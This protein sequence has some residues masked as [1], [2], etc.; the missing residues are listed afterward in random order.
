MRDDAVL[1]N[2]VITNIVDDTVSAVAA[3]TLLSQSAR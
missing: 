1:A 3:R 2:V